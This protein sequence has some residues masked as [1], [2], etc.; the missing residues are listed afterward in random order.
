L[1]S[2]TLEKKKKKDEQEWKRSNEKKSWCTLTCHRCTNYLL[3]ECFLQHHCINVFYST[4]ST[5][6][7]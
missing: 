4:I 3:E 5:L 6:I 1:S 2:S 7:L